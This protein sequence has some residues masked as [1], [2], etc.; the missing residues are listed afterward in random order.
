MATRLQQA[1]AEAD[2]TRQKRWA[3]KVRTG[4]QTCR[5]RRVKCDETQPRCKRCIKRGLAC[6]YTLRHQPVTQ[7]RPL[8]P[9]V[10][11]DPP[12]WHYME[13]IR[14]YCAFVRPVRVAQ[15][16]GHDIQDPPFHT[17]DAMSARFVCQIIGHRALTVSRR[18]GRLVSFWDDAQFASMRKT[19]SRYLMEFLAIVNGCL[20]DRAGGTWKAFHYLWSLLSFDLTLNESLWAAHVNG[21][22]AY[23]QL[24]GGPM[25]ALRLPGPTIFF[26]QMVLN[27]I[28][29]NATS[30]AAKQITGH[31]GYTDE[32][33]RAVLADED[34]I[35]PFPV[36]LVV[37]TKHIT[38]VRVQA[39]F[40]TKKAAVLQHRMQH[41]LQT[42]NAFD[43][44]TWAAD[45][46]I[47]KGPTT[48]AIGRIFQ[49][50]TRLYG[51]IALPV[52][53]TAAAPKATDPGVA[54]RDRLR[55]TQ[56]AEL[57]ARLR[58]VW[59]SLPDADNMV[60]PLLV[61]GVTLTDGQ[62]E[63]RAFVVGCLDGMWRRTLADVAPLLG[64][65]KLRRFWQSGKR[66]WEDCFH[67]PVPR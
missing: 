65:E 20:R 64:L 5:A 10:Q 40:Q 19:Y 49:I 15:H 44:D 37:V 1:E 46:A 21:A 34:S 45:L 13:A 14:Y 63:D 62:A 55:V 30:P 67:E 56:R 43:P 50:A 11:A 61:A 24:L 31:L 22:L 53:V 23:A 57:L 39:A 16:G 52:S 12:S 36:D 6:Q 27:A 59:P 47:D 3:P 41:L 54:S 29:S 51:I 58:D 2:T 42:I 66:G 25:A 18:R 26:R 17:G 7:V 32:E 4:C 38:E 48:P 9:L 33:I 8:A 60:W 28:V 35:W